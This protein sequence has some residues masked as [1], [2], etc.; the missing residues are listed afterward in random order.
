MAGNKKKP[1][2]SDTATVQEW[3]IVNG[4]W[5]NLLLLQYFLLVQEKGIVE[6]KSFKTFSIVSLK[7]I[8]E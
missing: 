5:I 2:D 8:E 7:Q 6:I 3:T 1:Y 4:R